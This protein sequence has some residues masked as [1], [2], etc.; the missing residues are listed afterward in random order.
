[1]VSGTGRDYFIASAADKIYID[2]AGALRLVGI[3]GSSVYFRGAFDQIG[4][5]PQFEKIAEYKSAP[6][7]FTAT[8][9]SPDA[10]RMYDELYDSLWDQW[11]TAIAQGRKL[12]MADVKALVDAGPYTAGDLAKDTRLVDAVAPPD[13]VSQLI[14]A[15]LGGAYGVGTAP[16]NRPERWERPIVAIIYVDG[17]ITD[18]KSQSIPILGRSLAGGETVVDAITAARNNPDV[19]AIVL[20]INSPGGSALA[21]ELIAREIFATRGVKP[22]IC[23]MSDYAASGGYFVAAGC[24]TIYAEPTTITGSI[25]IFYGKFDVSGLLAKLGVTIET[26]TRG[27][28]AD[29]ESFFRPYTEDERKVLLDKL[30]YMYGRFVGAVSDGRKLTK[31]EVDHIGRG[32]VWTGVQ[33]QPIKLVDKLGGLGDA[34]DEAKRR[35]GL[36]LDTRVSVIELPN[37]AKGL[38]RMIRDLLGAHANTPSVLELPAIRS[39]LRAVP[40]SVLVS[41]D[42]PQAR[43]P[44]DILFQ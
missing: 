2:P 40:G 37:E 7:Q 31:D 8:H 26:H 6:E 28:H 4:V 16:D 24:D 5:L 22:I 34:L 14:V 38:H 36:S 29:A 13:K 21:S 44:V 15:E 10:A 18:G 30:R 27:A 11:A 1:M 9:A 43:L 42:A 23:S 32:H 19:K 33:A 35:S 25:G 17:D 3:S 20:R 39:M 41:P 12:T